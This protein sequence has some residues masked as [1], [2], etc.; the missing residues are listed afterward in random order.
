ME[1]GIVLTGGGAKLKGMDQLFTQ[2]LGVPVMVAP[3]PELAVAKGTGIAVAD[4]D[5]LSALVEGAQRI[6]RRRF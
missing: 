3:E 6:Y 5:K 4:R 2:E 1:H